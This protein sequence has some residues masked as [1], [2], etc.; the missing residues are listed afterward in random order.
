[1]NLLASGKVPV[2]VS[3]YLAG[4][5]LTALVKD[6]P[7]FPPDI[8]PIVEGEALRHLTGKCLCAV[9]KSKASEFFA[10]FQFGVA[11]P[12]GAEK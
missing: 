5:S 7:G 6:K 2:S 3:Q 9:Q 1:M 11:C 12:V 8:R 10:P 4:G